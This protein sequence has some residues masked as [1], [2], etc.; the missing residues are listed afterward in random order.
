MSSSEISFDYA[1][2]QNLIDSISKY[3]A[4]I[5]DVFAQA[6]QR[7]ISTTKWEGD[8]RI[9]YNERFNKEWKARM[10]RFFNE[11]ENVKS[12]LGRISDAK[13]ETANAVTAA[14]RGS[15]SSLVVAGVYNSS[16]Q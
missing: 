3:K 2:A 9:A 10:E 13:R 15:A 6:E 8:T 5:E 12:S 7:I 11:L 14:L 4:K 16:G 1:K